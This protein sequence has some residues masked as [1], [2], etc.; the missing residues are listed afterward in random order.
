MADLDR[1]SALCA[2]TALTG[3]DFVQVVDPQLQTVLRVYFVVEPSL[4]DTPM[5]SPAALIAPAGPQLAGPPVPETVL[6]VVIASTESGIG[7]EID[8]LDWRLVRAPAGIRLTLEI[9]VAAPG[10]FAIHRLDI[11][12]P[13]VDP[14]FNGVLFSFKQ[15]CPSEFDCRTDCEPQPEE[16]VDFPVDY[17]ARDFHSLRRALLDFAAERYP[18]WSDPLEA[19]QAVMLMEI[20]AALG[21]ELAYTQDRYAREASLETATQRRSRSALARLVDYFPDPGG[22]AETELAV[23]VAAGNG[24]A[25]AAAGVRVWALIDGGAPVPFTV[26]DPIWHH[27]AWSQI[28]LHCPDSDTACLPR[29]STEA[30]LTTDSPTAAELPPGTPLSPDEFWIGRRVILRSQPADPAV[31]VRAWAVTVTGIERLVDELVLTNGSP[32][33]LTKIAWEKPTPWPL[34]LAETRALC[35]V[36]TA[37]AG[38]ELT[39]YF[40]VGTDAEVTARFPTMTA[41]E[42]ADLLALP[43]AVERQGPYDPETGQ[44]GRVLRCGLRGSEQRG[45]G[46]RGPGD[47]ADLLSGTDQIPMLGLR[48]VLPPLPKGPADPL[49]ADDPAGL[50]WEFYR[51]I[52]TTDLDTAGY[53]LEEGV[54]REVVTHQTPFE[55]LVFQDYAANPG[56]TVRFGDGFFG[57]PPTPGAVVEVRYFTAPGTTAN[58]APDSVT[59]LSLPTDPGA[60]PRL[61]YADSVTNPLP[62]VSGR[63]E[64]TAETTRIDAPEAFRALPLR[65]VRPE[66]FR[67]IAERLLWV[68]RANAVT[69]WTGSWSTEFVTADPLGGFG[70]TAA[71][72]A[73]L[74]HVIDCVR[75]TTRDAR[76]IDPEYL[77]IDLAVKVCIAD[78]AYPGEVLPRIERALAPPGFFDPDNF[79]FGQALNRS[80][81]E[82]R[83]HAVPGVKAVEAIHLRVRR[84]RDWQPFTDPELAVAPGQIVRLQNDPLFP[85]RGSLRVRAHGESS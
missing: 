51:D 61:T 65:A 22:A 38:E 39:E 7:I 11:G 52:L 1:K 63:D 23:W 47:P 56:W 26:P 76:P 42:S 5:V 43:R 15:G 34:P 83:V 21:D 62:I 20:M 74:E 81:I 31:E 37:V 46:W 35:N 19:D 4:L 2:Q 50:A 80:A 45:L 60:G 79:T 32:T 58:L 84:R 67:E 75:Q 24:G 77:D 28:P 41:S 10:D 78:D 54:W 33:P 85:G 68:Q 69:C 49:P 71:E 27:E 64:E 12:D 16:M 36:L 55:D 72:R 6:P 25:T 30:Y 14:F 44:R 66:D 29:G 73:E 57:R 9:G 40:R 17:Q 53:T 70:L 48:E 3:I 8:A 18:R 82:A 59:A 13:R